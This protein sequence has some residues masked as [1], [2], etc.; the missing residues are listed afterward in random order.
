M[1]NYLN[2]F[3][4]IFF[5]TYLI[6][7][8][9]QETPISPHEPGDIVTQQIVLEQDY[10]NQVFYNFKNNSVVSDNIKTDWDLGF[11]MHNNQDF[12]V[13][14]SST[15]M[16]VALVNTVGF[17]E[18]ININNLEWQ[19][20]NPSGIEYGTEISCESTS[21][22]IYIIDRG[23]LL[24]GNKRG[25][26]KLMIQ[27][28]TNDYYKIR[29]ADL[30]NSGD[31]VIQ[32]NKENESSFISY[33]FNIDDK[34]SVFPQSDTWDLVFTQYTDFFSD[35]TTP[36]YLVTGVLT[37]Y[38]NNILVAL[39]TI[40]EFEQITIEMINNYNFSNKQNE[41]GYNWKS[42]DLENNLYSINSS[43]IYIIRDVDGRYF[44]MRF[45]DFYNDFGEKGYPQ[46]QLQ[47][48]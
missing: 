15:F 3:T 27:E 16:Q 46:F 48:L 36:A 31:T 9:M 30:D 43:M 13:L 26:K 21:N 34:T 41:I 25:Y 18:I 33:S 23:Y 32:I 45:I 4:F 19:W 44:K 42:F 29:Y 1:K 11:V 28:V 2:G 7:C 38:L 17:E 22:N 47:E 40:N 39:D 10:K 14:N 12:I 5:M 8:E 24:N 6:S 37:N 35:T 20:D